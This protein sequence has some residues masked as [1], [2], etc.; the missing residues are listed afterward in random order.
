M[1]SSKYEPGSP[2]P[3]HEISMRS[4]GGH[5]HSGHIIQNI[6]QTHLDHWIV[7]KSDDNAV[8]C[9]IAD[10]L[11]RENEQEFNNYLNR[12]GEIQD[13]RSEVTQLLSEVRHPDKYDG[14]MADALAMALRGHIASA[15]KQ[16]QVVV[17]HIKNDIYTVTRFLYLQYTC[18]GGL[19]F[20]VLIGIAAWTTYPPY[21]AFYL[22]LGGLAGLAG[23]IFSIVIA[24]RSRAVGP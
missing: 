10:E 19:I 5:D 13:L 7:Y 16:L 8:H 17:D 2:K 24:I 18:Y 3:P 6:Y 22:T 14:P 11:K 15:R 12:L 20:G 23:A 21:G 1:F 9:E 4:R